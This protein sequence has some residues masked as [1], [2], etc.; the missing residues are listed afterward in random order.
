MEVDLTTGT[1]DDLLKHSLLDGDD[2]L[3]ARY[4]RR[5]R[6]T[7]KY[8]SPSA[9]I[10]AVSTNNSFNSSNSESTTMKRA[11]NENGAEKWQEVIDSDLASLRCHRT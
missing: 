9:G 7:S 6:N 1:V 10:T 8:Y 4:P 11:L 5:E 2:A 3:E